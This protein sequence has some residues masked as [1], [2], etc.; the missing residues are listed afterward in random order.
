MQCENNNYGGLKGRL[1]R[2]G[3]HNTPRVLDRCFNTTPPILL[4]IRENRRAHR[5]C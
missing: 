1:M 5:Y 3:K 4:A 2:L